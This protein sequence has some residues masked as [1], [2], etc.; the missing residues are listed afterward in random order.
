M[1]KSAAIISSPI[2]LLYAFSFGLLSTHPTGPILE[3]S[4]N[5]KTINVNMKSSLVSERDSIR[6][7]EN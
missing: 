5:L 7:N 6:L 3:I 2:T 4:K 1:D